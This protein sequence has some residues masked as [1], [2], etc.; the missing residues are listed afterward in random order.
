MNQVHETLDKALKDSKSV[1]EDEIASFL[2]DDELRAHKWNCSYY[3][4]KRFAEI[5]N[6]ETANESGVPY[7]ML[8]SAHS[9][10]GVLLV[11]G[12]LASPAEWCAYAQHLSQQGFA[13]LGVRLSGHGTSPWDL[14]GRHWK[15]WLESVSRGYRI[16]SAFTDKIV[17]AGFSSGGILGL[18]H[19]ATNPDNLAGVIAIN[20]PIQF[21]D[22]KMALVPLVHGV[23]KVSN[24]LPMI[25]EV[26]PFRD[27]DSEHPHINYASIPIP[28]LFELRTMIDYFQDLLPNVQAPVLLMQSDEDP[29]VHPDSARSIAGKLATDYSIHW[30][31]SDRHIIIEDGAMGTWGHMDEFI[32]RITMEGNVPK[33]KLEV[34]T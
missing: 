24:W 3:G 21:R 7:L 26:I 6:K 5:N 32:S 8:P 29:V 31:N 10:V 12:L 16:L 1:S 4:D 2:F 33:E 15:D 13:V 25:D 23:N 17:I 28:A 20:S 30:I 27:N 18:I 19:G 11:H 9:R 34:R 14:H 22:R